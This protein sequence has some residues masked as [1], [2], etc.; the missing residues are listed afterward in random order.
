MKL[1]GCPTRLVEWSFNPNVA[2]YF[3]IGDSSRIHEDGE[4]WLVT[5]SELYK[6]QSSEISKELSRTNLYYPTAH[7]QQEIVGAAAAK[8]PDNDL[9]GTLRSYE[10]VSSA[11]DGSAGMSFLEP[12]HVDKRIINQASVYAVASDPTV[13]LESVLRRNPSSARRVVVPCFLKQIL[14][15]TLNLVG[16]HRQWLFPSGD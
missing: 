2:L 8:S 10:A 12:M 16:I 3:A 6:S 13:G 11:R 4:I 1:S 15:Q 7:Q 14:L 9:V 5:P